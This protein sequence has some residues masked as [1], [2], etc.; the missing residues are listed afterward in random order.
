LPLEVAKKD[1]PLFKHARM[2]KLNF[3][4]GEP[5]IYPEFTCGLAEYCKDDLHIES[6][7]IVTNGSPVKPS[8]SASMLAF[9][10]CHTS[11]SI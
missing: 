8:S 6:V 11:N 5:L 10:T 4:D 2:R 3:A 7:S 9:F 1:L